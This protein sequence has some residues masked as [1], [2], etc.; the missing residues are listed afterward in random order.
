LASCSSPRRRRDLC[1]GRLTPHLPAL[2]LGNSPAQRHFD[3]CSAPRVLGSVPRP[4]VAPHP[5]PGRCFSWN[6]AGLRPGRT[7]ARG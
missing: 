5:G 6:T 2:K 7:C 1:D 3:G 4:D